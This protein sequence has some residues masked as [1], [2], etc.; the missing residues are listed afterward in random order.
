MSICPLVSPHRL[1][2]H[3]C[4][5]WFLFTQQLI[6]TYNSRWEFVERRVHGGQSSHSRS[7]WPKQVT[8]IIVFMTQHGNNY[9]YASQSLGKRSSFW[10]VDLFRGSK[11]SCFAM[12][13][14]IFTKQ[15]MKWSMLNKYMLIL[16]MSKIWISCPPNGFGWQHN[17]H[18]QKLYSFW[19]WKKEKRQTCRTL[20]FCFLNFFLSFYMKYFHFIQLLH[21]CQV[22]QFLGLGCSY[23]THV[24][25]VVNMF[26]INVTKIYDNK[27]E[28]KVSL[29]IAIES[30]IL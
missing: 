24:T 29:E 27:I 8:A 1:W 17:I 22:P 28:L 20:V 7:F 16:R 13:F 5:I 14:A 18:F 9:S 4:R 3:H 30:I 26:S 25:L 19:Y 11:W 6:Y 12:C 21:V 10:D 2:F 23:I 15:E